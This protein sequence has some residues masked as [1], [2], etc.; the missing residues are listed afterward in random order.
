V[1]VGPVKS[2]DPQ[3][4]AQCIT[5]KGF[6]EYADAFDNDLDTEITLLKI[7]NAVLVQVLLGEVGDVIDAAEVVVAETGSATWAFL[8]GASEE[9]SEKLAT[10]AG[11]WVESGNTGL[12]IYEKYDVAREALH[13]PEDI[14]RIRSLF[15]CAKNSGVNTATV[16][17][18]A[19]MTALNQLAES[20]QTPVVA[21]VKAGRSTAVKILVGAVGGLIAAG[22]VIIAVSALTSNPSPNSYVLPSSGSGQVTSPNSGAAPAPAA[23]YVHWSCGGQSQCEQVMGGAYGMGAGPVSYATCTDDL[24]SVGIAPYSDGTGAWCSTSPAPANAP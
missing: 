20:V 17:Y 15:T 23:Y 14:T 1:F 5:E 7:A 2:F 19:V 22:A 12:D 3:T 10:R 24:P 9:V 21:A 4:F 18:A 8:K 11:T 6:P 13:S 16:Q